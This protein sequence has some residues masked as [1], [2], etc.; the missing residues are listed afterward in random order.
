MKSKKDCSHDVHALQTITRRRNQRENDR[1]RNNVYGQIKPR[2]ARYLDRRPFT[3]NRPA[4]HILEA[5]AEAE[6]IS[7]LQPTRIV[8]VWNGHQLDRVFID[9]KEFKPV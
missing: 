9:G 4:R 2:G 5:R 7:E 3:T 1:P 8:A 6:R